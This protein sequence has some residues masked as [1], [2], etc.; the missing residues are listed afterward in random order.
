MEDEA[1]EFEFIPPAEILSVERDTWWDNY[2]EVAVKRG[3]GYFVVKH[4]CP[5]GLVY[6]SQTWA[7]DELDAYQRVMRGDL[8]LTSMEEQTNA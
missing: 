4:K 1:E 8:A 7:R 3:W 2:P 6:V 5:K